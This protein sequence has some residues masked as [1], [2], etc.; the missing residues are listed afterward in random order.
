MKYWVDNRKIE[1]AKIVF[2]V[3]ESY[4]QDTKKKNEAGGIILGEVRE[5]GSVYV[6]NISIPNIFDKANR[7]NFERDLTAAQII[8]NH[9]FA[10]SGRQCIYL[11]EWHTHPERKPKA[12]GQDKWM[13]KDQFEKGVLNEPFILLV[14]QG[15][16][17]RYVALYNGRKLRKAKVYK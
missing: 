15:I 9:E 2:K 13:I 3:M 7:Y 8:V 4:I 6:N 5:D 12:S 1:F 11:G 17:E 16:K 14:I 10:N